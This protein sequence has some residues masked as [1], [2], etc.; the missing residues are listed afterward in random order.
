M[1]DFKTARR[2]MVDGQIRTNDV[3]NLALI[4]AM[5]DIPREIFLPDRLAAF[6]YLDRDIAF[7]ETAGAARYLT[8]PVVLARLI[9]ALEP[10]PASRALVVGCGAGYGAAV[11]GRLVAAVTAVEENAAIAD[12]A[13]ATLA[14]LGANNVTVVTGALVGGYPASQPYD[15]ILIDGGIEIVPEALFGQ[16]AS[17]G[18]LVAV[19]NDSPGGRAM[20][21]QSDRGEVSGRSL[22]DAVAPVLPG[23]RKAPAFV[24]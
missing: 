22:F 24:F 18:R 4:D 23:F 3:T 11:L 9:Q 20:L 16:L 5:M 15:S 7:D 8:K 17:S 21:Y 2:A 12:R 13:K 19:I 1:V 10:T 14:G 6:A